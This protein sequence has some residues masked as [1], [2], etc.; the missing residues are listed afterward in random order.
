MLVIGSRLKWLFQGFTLFHVI[1]MMSGSAIQLSFF[2]ISLLFAIEGCDG[3]DASEVDEVALSLSSETATLAPTTTTTTTTETECC[4]GE[5]T[6]T[7]CA[8]CEADFIAK[9]D[10]Y[11]N[12]CTPADDG[13]SCN[14]AAAYDCSFH[15]GRPFGSGRPDCKGYQ[16]KMRCV[17]DHGCCGMPWSF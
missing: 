1:A 12:S 16:A 4:E 15:Y 7:Q 5:C 3:N 8:A 14:R 10:A 9:A 17:R 6:Q 2:S 13:S 11:A